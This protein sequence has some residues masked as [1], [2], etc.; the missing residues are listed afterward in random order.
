M[1]KNYFKINMH[2]NENASSEEEYYLADDFFDEDYPH[3]L[4]CRRADADI[5]V[6]DFV[7][8]ANGGFELDWSQY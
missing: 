3:E 8:K 1:A 6:K 7:K 5:Y 2:T 4:Y